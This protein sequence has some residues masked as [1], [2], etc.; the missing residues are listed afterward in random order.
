MPV[1]L[2]LVAI[3][4]ELIRLEVVAELQDGK[5]RSLEEHLIELLARGECLARAKLGDSL[6]VKAY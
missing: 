1:Y 3:D 4:A 2:E 6:A 5:R